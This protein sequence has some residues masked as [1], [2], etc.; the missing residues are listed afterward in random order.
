MK[1]LLNLLLLW[2]APAFAAQTNF[3]P[4][5]EAGNNTYTNARV[6]SVTATYAIVWH[7]GGGSRVFLTN[8]SKDLQKRFGYNATNATRIT[9]KEIAAEKVRQENQFARDTRAGVERS[10]KAEIARARAEYDYKF[11]LS[12]A[13]AKAALDQL[14]RAQ[15]NLENAQDAREAAWDRYI[16]TDSE[17]M[18]KSVGSGGRRVVNE[19]TRRADAHASDAD[20]RETAKAIPAL[21]DAAAK[22]IKEHKEEARRLS[23]E[24]MKASGEIADRYVQL[25]AQTE[26]ALSAREKA[27]TNSGMA[28]TVAPN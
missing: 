14:N 21:K 28:P 17:V 2:C 6:T 10:Y 7:A 22:A 23:Q 3:F 20:V 24:Y 9:A 8:F 13:K 18:H 16:Y 5:L 25:R 19:D 4:L 12:E 26:A 11:K 15:G 27:K 1:T